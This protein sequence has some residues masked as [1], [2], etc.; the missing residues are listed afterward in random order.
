MATKPQ[1]NQRRTTR[2]VTAV[3]PDREFRV[4][5]RA[6]LRIG[7]RKD[8]FLF[9]CTEEFELAAATAELLLQESTAATM[10][11]AVIV[12]IDRQARLWN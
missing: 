8:Q 4:L 3:K 10:V 7:D 9:R 12:G 6:S 2:T 11:S 5:W 1:K